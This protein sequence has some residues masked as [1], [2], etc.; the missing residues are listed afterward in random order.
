[1]GREMGMELTSS[2]G[3]RLVVVLTVVVS[4]MLWATPA[5]AATWAPA[6]SATIHPGVQTVTA[7]GQC[8]AN[9]IFEAGDDILIGQA[10]HCSGLGGA[11]ATNGCETE[12]LDLE[13]PVDIEGADH[14]G[15]LVYSSWLTMQTVGETDPNACSYNDFA[16][17][18]IHPLDHAKVNPSLPVWGGPVGVD[19]NGSSAGESVFTYGNSSLRLG[20][21]VLSPKTGLSLGTAGGGWTTTMLTATPGIPGDSG[22]AVLSQD[23]QA[24]GI[25]VTLGLAPVP[26]SNGVTSLALALAY[27]N[28]VGGMGASLASGTEAFAGL[29][30]LSGILS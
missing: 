3:R 13:T 17:V 2:R 15:T 29:G 22:S 24:L 20:L 30:G 1:M 5:S 12:S 25:L 10:A 27:A 19:T 11:T 7:G 9:F 28:D 8:T 23:G 14:P 21:S 16:L 26:A 4:G 18:R 6:D